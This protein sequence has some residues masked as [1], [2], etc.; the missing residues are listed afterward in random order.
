[1]R[2]GIK[3]DSPEYTLARFLITA[4]A[5]MPRTIAFRAADILAWLGYHSLAGSGGQAFTI[6][7]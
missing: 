3:E 6:S 4:F 1:M 5:I 2:G 7:G